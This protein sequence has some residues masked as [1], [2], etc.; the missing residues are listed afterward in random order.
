MSLTHI[1]T[2]ELG[3]SQ[4][5]ITF[6]SISQDFD[7][8][9]L[10]MSLRTNRADVV[11]IIDINLNGSS[12]NFSSVSLQGDGSSVTTA[13]RSTTRLLLDQ[14]NSTTANTFGNTQVYISNYTASQAKSISVDGAS[15]NNASQA[16]QLLVAMLW[17]DTSAITSLNLAPGLGTDFLTGSTFSLYGVTSGGS[18]TVT[19]S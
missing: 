3:S 1:E 17:N 6:S 10:K 12:S 15:E 14:A 13:S 2:I 16:F 11:D 7:D 8:L 5:S 9:V 18:G 19:T 4:S